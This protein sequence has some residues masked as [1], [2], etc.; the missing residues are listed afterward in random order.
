MAKSKRAKE[1]PEEPTNYIDAATVAAFSQVE[2]A[3]LAEEAFAFL[4][5]VIADGEYHSRIEGPLAQSLEVIHGALYKRISE[6]YRGLAMF[7]SITNDPELCRVA[8]IR[9]YDRFL[10]KNMA[11]MQM[12]DH[13]GRL[14]GSWSTKVEDEF[15]KEL[16]T[17]LV[18]IASAPA[19]DRFSGDSAKRWEPILPDKYSKQ[20]GPWRE[21]EEEYDEYDADAEANEIL[22]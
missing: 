16:K 2:Y 10:S 11:I 7:G 21:Y 17:R 20:I 22:P 3:E 5:E 9:A 8:R 1:K 4:R 14:P 13:R 15:R 19:R 18:E 6:A 12:L